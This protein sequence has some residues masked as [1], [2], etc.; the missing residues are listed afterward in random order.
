MIYILLILN[1]AAN[2]LCLSLLDEA[3]MSAPFPIIMIPT[4]SYSII[5]RDFHTNEH[6]LTNSLSSF[7]QQQHQQQTQI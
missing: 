7:Q 3:I 4:Q 2:Y 6:T 1:E 5:M